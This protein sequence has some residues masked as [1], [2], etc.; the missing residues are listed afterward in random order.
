[1]AGKLLPLHR[2]PRLLILAARQF[3]LPLEQL[4]FGL[5]QI[6]AG[7]LAQ[8]DLLFPATSR[9]NRRLST[10]ACRSP[11]AA[12]A[13]YPIKPAGVA[14]APR[15]FMTSIAQ[16]GAAVLDPRRADFRITRCLTRQAEGPLKTDLVLTR[17]GALGT[18]VPTC[19]RRR[20][21]AK[22][23]VRPGQRSRLASSIRTPAPA[24]CTRGCS[25]RTTC[26]AGWQIRRGTDPMLISGPDSAPGEHH[27]QREHQAGTAVAGAPAAATAAAAPRT[28]DP[29]RYFTAS[30]IYFPA[31][32]QNRQDHQGRQR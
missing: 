26:T 17:A 10:C 4:R 14:A 8:L 28:T 12:A 9:C 25:C 27:K 13:R 30:I 16:R 22:T 2:Q 19:R 32:I 3:G 18:V 15:R 21:P 23:T 24:A 7:G 31:T 6:E 5:Q 29:N 11:T 1:M 20:P